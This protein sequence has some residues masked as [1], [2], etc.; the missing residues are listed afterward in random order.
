VPNSLKT[1]PFRPSTS[2]TKLFDPFLEAIMKKILY[3]TLLI[4]AAGLLSGCAGGFFWT[5]LPNCECQ[6]CNAC[7]PDSLRGALSGL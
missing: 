1:P 3:R 5:S 2:G 4:V 7:H 6:G